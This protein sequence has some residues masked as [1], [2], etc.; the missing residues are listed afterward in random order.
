ME[1]LR[2]T[3]LVDVPHVYETAMQSGVINYL[4]RPEREILIMR[5]EEPPRTQDE[6]ATKIGMP[7]R[8]VARIESN[9]ISR[10]ERHLKITLLKQGDY[11]IPSPL[12]ETKLRKSVAESEGTE[13]GGIGSVL[14]KMLTIQNMT[15]REAEEK[16]GVSD[17]TIHYWKNKL[18]IEGRTVH[19]LRS[20]RFRS[21]L[22][23]LAID[24]ET[25]KDTLSRLYE[26]HSLRELGKIF[27]SSFMTVRQH[28]EELE[29][30]RREPHVTFIPKK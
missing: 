7:T 21:M 12:S 13:T 18:N 3:I 16:L 8:Y 5:F 6:I 25:P 22:A 30:P 28:M 2:N 4:S 27:Q 17:G 1:K 11:L 29:I 23:S 24:Q 20:S 10:I 19:S 9:A 14:Y 15:L 26:T